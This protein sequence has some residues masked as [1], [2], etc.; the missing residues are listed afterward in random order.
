LQAFY[1]IQSVRLVRVLS[2]SRLFSAVFQS[3]ELLEDWLGFLS[4]P[5]A[6]ELLAFQN[7]RAVGV[8]ELQAAEGAPALL[9]LTGVLQ[10][11]NRSFELYFACLIYIAAVVW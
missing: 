11:P 5:Q 10:L 1:P 7:P 6:F 9:S 8:Q 3:L 4:M 2:E